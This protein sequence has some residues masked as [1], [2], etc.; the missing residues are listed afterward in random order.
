MNEY[1]IIFADEHWFLSFWIIVFG[2]FLLKAV[3]WH[4]PNRILRTINVLMRGWPPAHIDADGD[5]RPQ[6]KPT[7]PAAAK[8]N[9]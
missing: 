8:D 6:P 5:W 2:Y 4:L 9:P 7:K 3:L 1:V